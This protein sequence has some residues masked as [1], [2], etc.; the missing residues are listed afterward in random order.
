MFWAEAIGKSF[1][2]LFGRLLM[3]SARFDFQPDRQ[4]MMFTGKGSKNGKIY[5]RK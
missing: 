5:E 4:R 1:I 3:C 2:V